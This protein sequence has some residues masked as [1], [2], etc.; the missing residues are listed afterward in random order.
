MGMHEYTLIRVGDKEVVVGKFEAAT[1]KEAC[2]KHMKA[3][4]ERPTHHAVVLV[5][6]NGARN[7][8]RDSDV[9]VRTVS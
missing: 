2:I 3:W 5:L 6:P 9:Y 1:T 4:D 7:S 8:Y